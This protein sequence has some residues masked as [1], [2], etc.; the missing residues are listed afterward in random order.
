VTQK[1]YYKSEE[2]SGQGPLLADRIKERTEGPV[3]EPGVWNWKR[4]YKKNRTYWGL[5]RAPY[6]RV[7]WESNFQGPSL[8][9]AKKW[10]WDWRRCNPP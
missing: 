1:F 7:W 9:P 10:I 2:V 6:A 3:T 8:C 4:G 5:S